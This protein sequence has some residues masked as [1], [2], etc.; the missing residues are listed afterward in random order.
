MFCDFVITT[1]RSF[2]DIIL[3]EKEAA[4]P[5]FV[6]TLQDQEV[7]EGEMVLFECEVIEENQ[8]NLIGLS[9]H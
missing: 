3:V 2:N 8:F 6:T 7:K 4:P 5:A 1:K 9:Y